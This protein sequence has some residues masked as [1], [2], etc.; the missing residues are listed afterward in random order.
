[1]R[2]RIILLI[3][4]FFL[5]C[6]RLGE[7]SRFFANQDPSQIF[8]SKFHEDSFLQKSTEEFFVQKE[9][10]FQESFS[11]SSTQDSFTQQATSITDSFSHTPPTTEILTS[12][13]DIL[14]VVDNS[15]SMAG[16]Q[17]A[18]ANNFSTFIDNF[19]TE[20]IDF[21]IGILTSGVDLY[22][23]EACD[24]NRDTT[25]GLTSAKAKAD[26]AT[27][28]NL[29]KTTIQVGTG[30][31]SYEKPIHCTVNFI[32]NN[33][34]WSRLNTP[35][36]VIIVSDENESELPDAN[37]VETNKTYL[38]TIKGTLTVAFAIVNMDTSSRNYGK[39]HIELA[40]D[41][42][43]SYQSITD[44]FDG[45]LN[46]FGSTIS[47][48]AKKKKFFKIK[49][50]LTAEELNNLRV[51]VNGTPANRT[52][53][54]TF[55]ATYNSVVFNESFTFPKNKS[56]S[57]TVSFEKSKS[58]FPLNRPLDTT[59]LHTVE[60]RV[61]GTP[62]PRSHW[63]YDLSRNSIQFLPG[64]VPPKGDTIQIVYNR[65]SE[66]IL[67]KKL[68]TLVLGSTEV[69][70]NGAIIPKNFWQYNPSNNSI[71]LINGYI[72]PRGSTIQVVY[73]QLLSQFTLNKPLDISFI[74]SMQVTVDNKP[75]T[76]SHWDYDPGSNAIQFK[77]AHIPPKG[78]RI[79]IIYSNQLSQFKLSRPLD[80]SVLKDIEIT[81]DGKPFSKNFWHYDKS[82]NS[83]NIDKNH[84]PTAGSTIK[85][86]YNNHQMSQFKLKKKLKISLLNNVEITINGNPVPRNHWKYDPKH[87]NSIQ[88]LEGYI[89]PAGSKV[90]ITYTDA[91]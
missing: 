48:M 70:V 50:K 28:K 37:T 59:L 66:F 55:N 38:K 73:N 46:S 87:D 23:R 86:I 84:I 34:S 43:G 62:L 36:A 16:E 79:K 91:L 40:T 76:K 10:N 15:G 60:I 13:V 75:V 6:G 29:F 80:I 82:S 45:I 35:L 22:T 39:H 12:A 26:E 8:T 25:G 5:G 7:N 1:M 21:K 33:P 57:V 49:H 90:K 83:I 24:N 64:R 68:N 4:A 3:F 71:R 20:D 69:L 53:N 63:N 18:L 9:N 41:T 89:P 54:W 51:T 17:T 67:K 58:R 2:N 30:G 77:Q 81:I 44:P 47:K 78:S 19:L 27:F 14:F 42:G 61:N 52:T 31:D 72:A 74:G 56:S 65:V 32:K 11:Q 85:I 88:F